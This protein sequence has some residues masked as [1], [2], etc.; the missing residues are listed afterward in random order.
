MDDVSAICCNMTPFAQGTAKKKDGNQEAWGRGFLKL[1]LVE[2]E[3][4]IFF[5]FWEEEIVKLLPKNIACNKFS[6]NTTQWI[7]NTI[8]EQRA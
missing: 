6:K 8:L 5:T 2:L 7:T 4:D 1:F 3:I